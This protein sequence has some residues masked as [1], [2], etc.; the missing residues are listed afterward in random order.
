M[1]LEKFGVSSLAF[2]DGGRIREAVEQALE[3]CRADCDDRPAEKKSRR[4]SLEIAFIPE[5]DPKGRLT[6]VDVS[7]KVVEKLPPRVSAVYA[8]KPRGKDLYFN[9]L[10]PDDPDQMTIDEPATGPRSTAHVG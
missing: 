2:L 6:G 3:R 4:L 10:S 8:M 5:C 1:T 7:F 9:E